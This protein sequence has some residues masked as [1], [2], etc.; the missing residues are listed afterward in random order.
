MND[1][2]N[3]RMIKKLQKV[4]KKFPDYIADLSNMRA[5][6]KINSFAQLGSL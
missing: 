6:V 1:A 2:S 4:E 3:I 5:F